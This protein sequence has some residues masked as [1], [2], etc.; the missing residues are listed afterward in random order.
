M[1]N[2]DKVTPPVEVWMQ[3][4]KEGRKRLAKL[5]LIHGIS[6]REMAQALGWSSHSY[7]GRLVRGQVTSVT[8][9]VAARI[10]LT[11]GVGIDDLFLNK[12]HSSDGQGAQPKTGRAA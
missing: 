3:F 6:Q 7:V 9:D 11:L 10:A 5:M 4:T 2:S 8:P 1:F 12:A